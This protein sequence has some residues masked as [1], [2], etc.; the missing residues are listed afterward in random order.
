MVAGTRRA[1]SPANASHVSAQTVQLMSFWRLVALTACTASVRVV[2][3][4]AR[5]VPDGC[6]L[7]CARVADR[8]VGHCQIGFLFAGRRGPEWTSQGSRKAG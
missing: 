2:D 6:E 5:C 3:H 4:K 7:V 8:F 1:S